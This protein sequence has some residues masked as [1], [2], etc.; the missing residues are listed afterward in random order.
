MRIWGDVAPDDA[1][2]DGSA[3]ECFLV[4]KFAAAIF[5]FADR[6]WLAEDADF[7]VG[8]SEIP[9]MGLRIVEKESEVLEMAVG[10]IGFYFFELG[11]AIPD[12]TDRHRAVHFRPGGRAG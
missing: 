9:L 11:A 2:Q 12:F 6:G 8:K 3:V 5:E 7:A 1:D 4:V 10:A